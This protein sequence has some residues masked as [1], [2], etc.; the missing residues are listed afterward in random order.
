MEWPQVC[1]G[2][3]SDGHGPHRYLSAIGA[4]SIE[5]SQLHP[6]HIHQVHFLTYTENAVPLAHPEWFDNRESSL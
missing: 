4:F 6:F 2:R 3:K 1:A 5:L